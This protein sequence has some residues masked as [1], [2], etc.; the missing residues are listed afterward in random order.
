MT[1]VTA[2]MTGRVDRGANPRRQSPKTVSLLLAS[3]VHSKPPWTQH[4]RFP[5]SVTSQTA[6]CPLC[7]LQGVQRDGWAT[8]TPHSNLLTVSRFEPTR[9]L[10]DHAPMGPGSNWKKLK[11]MSYRT[12]REWQ[13]NEQT[14]QNMGSTLFC[15][16]CKADERASNPV[17]THSPRTSEQ[18]HPR[19]FSR[20]QTRI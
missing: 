16:C 17:G 11:S 18:Q 9:Q 12:E 8:I 10:H 19:T 14:Y 7:H 1:Y 5:S 13:V 3:V 6:S 4:S 2:N 15:C 20:F